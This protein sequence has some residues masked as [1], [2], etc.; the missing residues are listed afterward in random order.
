MYS[1]LCDVF[2]EVLQ[3]QPEMCKELLLNEASGHLCGMQVRAESIHLVIHVWSVALSTLS[4][5]DLHIPCWQNNVNTIHKGCIY[6]AWCNALCC[7]SSACV[8]AEDRHYSLP[9]MCITQLHD[10]T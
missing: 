3:T 1:A 10:T 9:L 7:T 8:D 6:R 2:K 4:C 5:N